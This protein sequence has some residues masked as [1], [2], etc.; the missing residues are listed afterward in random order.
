[1][2]NK[3]YITWAE[4]GAMANELGEQIKKRRLRFN[5][6][7]GIPRG[8]LPLAVYLSYYLN[9]PLQLYPNEKSLVVDDISDTGK[10]LEKHSNKFIGTLFT[11]EYT[12]TKPHCWVDEKRKNEW[13]VFPWEIYNKKANVIK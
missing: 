1:M 10:T 3:I 11:T 6:I 8:G 9:L 12:K 2:K 5:G 4:F 7:Y 13:I